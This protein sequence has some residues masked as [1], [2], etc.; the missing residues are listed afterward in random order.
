MSVRTSSPRSS[1]TQTIGAQT[2]ASIIESL[3]FDV[4][5]D[6]KRKHEAHDDPT[7]ET[8]SRGRPSRRAPTPYPHKRLRTS[9]EC[10]TPPPSCEPFLLGAM[11]SPRGS[12]CHENDS[13]TPSSCPGVIE[14]MDSLDRDIDS[15]QANLRK[16]RNKLFD[17]G[18]YHQ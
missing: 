15:L 14:Y 17:A 2:R 4:D 8:D 10:T 13:A 5:R 18:D 1:A 12:P 16:L 3:A 11:R 7:V 6:L 9:T